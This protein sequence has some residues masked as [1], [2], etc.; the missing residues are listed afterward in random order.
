MSEN[1]NSALSELAYGGG[2]FE[3]DPVYQDLIKDLK[4][5]DF[6]KFKVA[7]TDGMDN[8]GV[9]FK[10]VLVTTNNGSASFQRCPQS[11]PLPDR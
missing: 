10:N 8:N 4:P 3:D 2:R 5:G 11:P 1:F 7:M 9:P 6:P